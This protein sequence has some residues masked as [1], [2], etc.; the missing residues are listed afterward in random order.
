[1]I[2]VG[3][4]FQQAAAAL[5]RDRHASYRLQLGSTLGFDAVAALAPTSTRSG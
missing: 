4:F 2:D 3:V 1:M 5:R